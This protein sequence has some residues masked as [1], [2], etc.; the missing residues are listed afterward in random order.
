VLSVLLEKEPRQATDTDAKT[1]A[2]HAGIAEG[3]RHLEFTQRLYVRIGEAAR[4]DYGRGFTRHLVGNTGFETAYSEA[5]AD[6]GLVGNALLISQSQGFLTVRA[7][8][9]IARNG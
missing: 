6:R 5:V 7:K 9:S 4:L 1:E 3:P 8:V 2:D